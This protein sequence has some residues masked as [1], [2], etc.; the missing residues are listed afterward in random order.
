MRKTIAALE[1]AEAE[2]ADVQQKKESI[3]V[4]RDAEQAT[5]HRIETTRD[6][7]QRD[8]LAAV[9]RVA[10]HEANRGRVAQQMREAARAL[11]EIARNS[12]TAEDG[13][14]AAQRDHDEVARNVSELEKRITDAQREVEIADAKVCET[15]RVL[16]RRREEIGS[17]KIRLQGITER[18]RVLE[19]LQQKQEGVSGGVREVLRMS[20]AELKK[21][22]RS[23]GKSLH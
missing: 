11:E 14:K 8:H 4:K 13:L 15:R 17:L 5:V 12:V 3:A 1:V 23:I 16:E 10:E 22:F 9:R 7:L 18:A 20:N 6:D 19:E 21:V 2:L